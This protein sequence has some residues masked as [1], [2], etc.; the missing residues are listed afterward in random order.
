M[1]TLLNKVS[2]RFAQLKCL[3]WY[4]PFFKHFGKNSYIQSPILISQPKYISVGDYVSIRKHA[5][6]EVIKPSSSVVQPHLEIGNHTN[7]E[8]NAHIIC[9]HH[10]KIGNYVSITGQC[11]I[12]DTYH[13]YADIKD[14][15]KIGDRLN[16][17]PAPVVIGDHC[18]IGFG[19][20]I[21]PNVTLGQYVIVGAHSVV[22][23]SVPD[24]C[25]VAGSPAKI[26]KR[27]NPETEVWESCK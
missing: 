16:M 9:Q 27:H 13:P 26:I 20:C 5:R 18:F 23:K 22:T 3:L 4:K 8:Q 15:R 7:I 21:M 1:W 25:V 19:S 24:Y 6:I 10:V 14:T 12:V 2:K 17:D 11:M